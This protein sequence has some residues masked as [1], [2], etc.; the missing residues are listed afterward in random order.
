MKCQNCQAKVIQVKDVICD[1]DTEYV[2]PIYGWEPLL[3]D[4]RAATIETE[5]GKVFGMRV[6]PKALGAIEGHEKHFCTF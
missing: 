4:K 3:G 1:A 2:K 5:H 6:S